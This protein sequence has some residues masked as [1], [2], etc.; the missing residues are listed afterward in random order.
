MLHFTWIFAVCQVTSIQSDYSD[1][2]DLDLHMDKTNCNG[3]SS[4]NI[5]KV[6]NYSLMKWL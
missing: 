2:C 3:Q 1:M 5:Y 4:K 6:C